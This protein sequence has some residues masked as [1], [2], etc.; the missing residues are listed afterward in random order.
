MLL[1]TVAR[2]R[3]RDVWR[4]LLDNHVFV[5][6]PSPFSRS[7]TIFLGGSGGSTSDPSSPPSWCA[8]AGLYFLVPQ[9]LLKLGNLGKCCLSLEAVPAE[10]GRIRLG[11]VV[12]VGELFLAPECG[13]ASVRGGH[14][15][16][17]Q[18][19]SIDARFQQFPASPLFPRAQAKKP[20]K[21]MQSGVTRL[22]MFQERSNLPLGKDGRRSRIKAS[23]LAQI[24]HAFSAALR[25]I[26]SDPCRSGSRLQDVVIAANH[27]GVLDACN[28]LSV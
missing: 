22:E 12:G 19:P 4:R 24:Y 10:V 7:S 14:A 2:V 9:L 5:I 28:F 6:P 26:I 23:A 27:I 16:D 15:Q 21:L 8:P 3:Q 25:D 17:P 18:P 11:K 1:V 20:I 13:S